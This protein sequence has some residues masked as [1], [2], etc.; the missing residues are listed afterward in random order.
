MS[1]TSN[2]TGGEYEHTLSYNQMPIHNHTTAKGFTTSDS[3]ATLFDRY[4]T[5]QEENEIPS[6]GQRH[7]TAYTMNAG[8]G[9]PHNNVQP[10]LIVYFWKRIN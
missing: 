9:K 10:Y 6:A 8:G 2:S 3:N 1:Y 7:W 4:T 5:Y